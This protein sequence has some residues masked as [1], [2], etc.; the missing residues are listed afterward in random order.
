MRKVEDLTGLSL[1]DPEDRLLLHLAVL[2][3]SGRR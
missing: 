1:D 2:V 3:G